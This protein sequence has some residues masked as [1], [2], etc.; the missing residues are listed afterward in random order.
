MTM[1]LLET[2]RLPSAIKT[3]LIQL[4]MLL[5]MVTGAAPGKLVIVLI[6]IILIK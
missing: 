1:Q 4:S 6:F 5:Q 3:V 2:T